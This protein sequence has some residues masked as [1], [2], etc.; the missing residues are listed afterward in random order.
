MF[1]RHDDVVFRAIASTRSQGDLHPL[2]T[3][4]RVLAQRQLDIAGRRWAMLD[5]RHGRDA[6]EVDVTSTW[7]VAG[8]GDNIVSRGGT[9]VGVW[10]ADC[11]PLLMFGTSGSVVGVHAGWRGLAAGVIDGGV[12]ELT[13]H[14][15]R[16]AR[17]V[18]GPVIHPCCYEFSTQDLEQV[19]RGVHASVDDVSHTT[20]SGA[21]ALDVPA[22]VCAALAV[23]GI[24][25][26]E[27]GDC[28]GCDTR[29]FSHRAGQDVGRHVL[30]G[31]VEP[32]GGVDD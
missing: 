30:V 19:A 20:I 26:D 24:T 8:V 12:D 14:G 17:V 28:T 18:L 15:E 31:W 13:A 11:A 5:Q 32:R 29:R 2:R 4:H 27:L 22:A 6:V 9:P 16:V 23:H 25:P 3:D 10:A 1:D 21:P 7:P